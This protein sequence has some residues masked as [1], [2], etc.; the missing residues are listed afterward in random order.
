[1]KYKGYQILTVT[2]LGADP[3]LPLVVHKQYTC[4]IHFYHSSHESQ[5][6]KE[7]RK[8]K[9]KLQNFIRLLNSVKNSIILN[10][11]LFLVSNQLGSMKLAHINIGE[12]N[13]YS[14]PEA[15]VNIRCC[16]L[17]VFG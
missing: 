13:R 11:I 1:M 4:K 12:D 9:V 2:A 3:T 15:D 14:N 5:T 8:K 10:M 17:F 7:E 6:G 16:D